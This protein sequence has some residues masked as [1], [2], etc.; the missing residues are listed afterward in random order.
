MATRWSE[1][2]P[3]KGVSV[4][5]VAEA[6]VGVVSHTGLLNTV[7]TDQGTVFTGRVVR[8]VCEIL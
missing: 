1:A 6:F 8:K 7:L 3:L 5:E 4:A 2:A